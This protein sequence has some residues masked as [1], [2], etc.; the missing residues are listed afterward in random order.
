HS[1]SPSSIF[2]LSLHDALPIFFSRIIIGG[3]KLFNFNLLYY[4]VYSP[5][6]YILYTFSRLPMDITNYKNVRKLLYRHTEHL[7]TVII[8]Y[9]LMVLSLILL[10][11]LVHYLY[12]I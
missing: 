5:P 12:M 2:S 11:L 4:H 9:S 1:T 7:V 6:D 3:N 10:V 8:K